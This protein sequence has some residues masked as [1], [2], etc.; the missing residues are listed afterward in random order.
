LLDGAGE[1]GIETFNGGGQLLY[2]FLLDGGRRRG[3]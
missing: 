1:E 3:R 2:H